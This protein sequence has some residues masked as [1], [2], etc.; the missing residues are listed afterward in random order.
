MEACVSHCIKLY[1]N[2]VMY[3]SEALI[4]ERLG[5]TSLAYHY[6][7]TGG[8]LRLLRKRPEMQVFPPKSFVL[9]TH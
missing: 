5:S 2:M 9:T 8:L 4:V 6:I 7:N 3:M 1:V